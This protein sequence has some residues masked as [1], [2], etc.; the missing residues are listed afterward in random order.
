VNLSPHG[1]VLFG[2]V[3]LFIQLLTAERQL[4]VTLRAEEQ[5]VHTEHVRLLRAYGFNS[6]K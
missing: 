1:Y 5:A 6:N 4:W 3:R 2:N